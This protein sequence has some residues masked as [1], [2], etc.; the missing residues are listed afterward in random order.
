M[1]PSEFVCSRVLG[2]VQGTSGGDFSARRCNVARS[3]IG[4]FFYLSLSSRGIHYL[5]EL[6]VG[7]ANLP[8]L[9]LVL[10]VWMVDFLLSVV[11][12]YLVTEILVENFTACQSVSC[13]DFWHVSPRVGSL[14]RQTDDLQCLE[15]GQVC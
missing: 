14:S 9:T 15:F 4:Q 13:C 7:A 1:L 10:C 11:A 5:T 2:A 3:D 8:S 12:H 6:V